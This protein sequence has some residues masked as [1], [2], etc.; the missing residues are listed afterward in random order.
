MKPTEEQIRRFWKWC[1]CQLQCEMPEGF[2]KLPSWSGLTP[3]G[4]L[5][6]FLLDL[7][8]IFRWAVPMLD[9][10]K[11]ITNDAPGGDRFFNGEAEYSGRRG[12]C[13]DEDPALALFWAI[14]KVIDGDNTPE[15]H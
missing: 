3:E 5:G 12:A 9:K 11:V 6:F 15:E 14:Y 10:A 8:N 1:R 4:R 13:T 2:D 7:S